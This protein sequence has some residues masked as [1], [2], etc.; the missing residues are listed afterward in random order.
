MFK[1][2]DGRTCLYQWDLDRKLV[3]EDINC[4]EVHFS[5]RTTVNSLSCKTYIENEQLVVDIPNILLQNDWEIT[6]YA[7]DEF[8]TKYEQV[9]KVKKRPKPTD[10]V[11]TETEILKW[12]TLEKKADDA[13]AKS[14]EA[15]DGVIK[16]NE[17]AVNANKAAEE[18]NKAIVE[19]SDT[20]ANALKG[21]KKG[22]IVAITDISPIEHDVAVKAASKNLFNN[23]TSLLKEVFYTIPTGGRDS[24]IGYEPL[25]L[26]AGIY[27]F[28][29]TNLDTSAQ[30]YIYGVIN[31]K[32][33]NFVSRCNLLQNTTN[34]T[35]LTITVNEGDKIFIYNAHADMNV[36]NR[37]AEFAAVEIQLE[38]GT[39][40][41]NYTPYVPD[42]SVATVKACGKNICD[43]T[44]FEGISAVD[45]ANV[46]LDGDTF[47]FPAGNSYYGLNMANGL[48]LVK[49][50]KYA[51]SFS[52]ITPYAYPEL[53]VI[54]TDNTNI[55]FANGSIKTIEKDVKE[56]RFYIATGTLAE[57]DFKLSK[58]QVEVGSTVTDYEPPI[59][60]T[61]YPIAADGIV[62][63]VTSIY[64]NMTITTDTI[65]V[66]VDTEYNRDIN[67]AFAELQQAII[68]LGGNI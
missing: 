64:P 55:A 32:D 43:Y 31:D 45:R 63:G 13:I 19:I 10:Y 29:L 22:G 25:I 46:V 28:T 1:I 15:L 56:I 44:K 52:A 23:D 39:T 4:S 51:V 16:A 53:Q 34:F 27:T 11:Y 12:E 48:P 21:N 6:A 41:T 68:S 14:Q 58:F 7:Y 5:N 42:V 57:T 26:P 37:A 61:S 65:G 47:I 35:P 24:R 2:Q 3:I 40:A 18:A 17:M 66:V 49:G 62:E 9:Y 30:K 50:Q 54:Y 36:A 60:P 8:Y 38:K 59:E 67:K 20:F 33:D